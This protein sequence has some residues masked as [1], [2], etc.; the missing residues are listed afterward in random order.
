MT[1]DK[2][3]VLVLYA[4]AILLLGVAFIIYK[5]PENIYKRNRE[6]KILAKKYNKGVLTTEERRLFYEYEQEGVI[7]ID[8]ACRT[9]SNP[10]EI[11]FKAKL[12][13]RAVQE[14]LG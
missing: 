13:D 7:K 3:A 12:S 6:A 14:V 2:L 1:P 10:S 11:L 8:I 5:A 4:L 9:S